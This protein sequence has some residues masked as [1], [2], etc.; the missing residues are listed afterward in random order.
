MAKLGYVNS[1]NIFFLA[2]NTKGDTAYLINRAR[3]LIEGQ[4]SVL[5]TVSTP[6]TAA[7]MKATSTLPIVFAWTGDPVQ[8]GFIVSY[9]TPKKNLTGVSS[10]AGPLAGKRLEILKEIDPKIK[11]VLALV[12]SKDIVAEPSYE[13]L[14][15]TAKRIGVHIVRSDVSSKTDIERALQAA[16]KDSFDAIYHVPSSLVGVN[17]KLLIKK[18]LREGLPLVVHEESMVEQG[19]LFTYAPDFN[20]V[21]YQAAR[22]VA[23]V[24]NGEKP[25]GIP[26]ETPEKLRFVVNLNTARAIKLKLSPEILERADR[27]VE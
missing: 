7:A 3:T 22:L 6:H 16:R 15:L 1:R 9:A 12:A 10:Y 21:G 17:I 5:F 20:L 24:L 19:A 26:A 11:N 2:E 8:S 4:P 23:K 14:E 27:V 13:F 25:S 18:S